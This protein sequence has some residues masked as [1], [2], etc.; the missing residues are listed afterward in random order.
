V[1]GLAV[2]LARPWLSADLGGLRRVL[3]F[4]PHRPGF[5]QADRILWREVR[6]ADLTPGFDVDG[7]F[8][9][10]MAGQGVATGFLTSRDIGRWQQARAEVDGVAAHAIAT[11]GLGNA[12][13][14]GTRRGPGSLI[15]WGTINI[16]VLIEGAALSDTALI[17]ALTIVAEART[18]AVMGAGL[19][20]PTGPVTG[21]GT[22]CIAIAADPG[23]V[24]FAGKH[25][26]LGEAV[27]RAVVQA[28]AAGCADW[29]AEFAA[30][31]QAN[32]DLR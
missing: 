8:A 21:T 30:E 18:L 26:A 24:A 4:A 1:S 6:N 17:E 20:L 2:T 14:V 3:S 5:V 29:T 23:E 7:W 15:R 28:V 32:S 11:V 25:T 22:D 9:G 16:A 10:E 13:S 19:R 31:L 27:G 12:E